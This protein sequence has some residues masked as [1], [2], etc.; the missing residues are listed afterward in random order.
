MLRRSVLQLPLALALVGA[1]GKPA[2]AGQAAA[3][4]LGDVHLVT[5]TTGMS[6]AHAIRHDD[7]R[8]DR[9]NPLHTGSNWTQS[10][11]STVAGGEEHLVYQVSA[12]P[13]PVSAL[14][15][16]RTRHLD[17]TWSQER[18]DFPTSAWGVTA[19]A[20]AN[21]EVHVVKRDGSNGVMRHLV[22][23]RDG[24]WSPP[25]DVPLGESTSGASLTNVNGVPHLV[26]SGGELN[27]VLRL[28]TRQADGTWSAPVDTAVL[29]QPNGL[30]ASANIAQV[31]TDL[32]AVVRTADRG[33]LHAIRRP[34]GSWTGWGD[35]GREAGVPGAAD[36]VAVTASRN[37]LHVAITTT[38]GGLFHT[39]RF[40]DGTWQPF[41]NVKGAAGQVDS[42][43]VTIA[44]E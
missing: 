43:E 6:V 32:H 30:S 16:L 41:G 34:D 33:L 3:Y 24:S 40:T 8:W 9:F 13:K 18:I 29:P 4:A 36:A 1:A 23:H 17:G 28:T 22:R 12:T 35:I 20:V 31:G 15:Y 25:V 26:V 39:I 11:S 38:D 7:G 10:L 42:R 21:G 14:T 5:G 44:G 37:T 19:V 2:Q 27:T